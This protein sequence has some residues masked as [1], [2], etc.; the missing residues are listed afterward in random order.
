MLSREKQIGPSRVSNLICFHYYQVIWAFQMC[1]Y[2]GSIHL[3][4]HQYIYADRQ[5]QTGG[6]TQ[7]D[8]QTDRHD[9]FC[10]LIWLII[11]MGDIREII[12]L[13]KLD[14]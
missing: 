14:F 10:K 13:N 9:I 1:V 2:M 7:T 8:R 6:R 4:V 12:C 11:K 3:Y 5:R